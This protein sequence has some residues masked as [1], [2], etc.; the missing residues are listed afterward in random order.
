MNI[1]DLYPIVCPATLAASLDEVDK[2]QSTLA[3]AL[4]FGRKTLKHA[5]IVAPIFEAWK[6]PDDEL[7][8]QNR[9]TDGLVAEQREQIRESVRRVVPSKRHY[10]YRPLSWPDTCSTDAVLFFSHIRS[11]L[12]RP[13]L[14]IALLPKL[15]LMNSVKSWTIS[16]TAIRPRPF[17]A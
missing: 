17:L 14:M 11:V 3:L 5:T 1:I 16:V 6:L 8:T 4:F 13:L 15:S 7:G 10:P 9:L 2:A 12:I